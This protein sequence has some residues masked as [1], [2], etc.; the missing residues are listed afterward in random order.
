MTATTDSSPSQDRQ[1]T[2]RM[3][4]T[5]WAARVLV[6]LGLAT[7]LGALIGGPPAH[8]STIVYAAAQDIA[9]T[10][11]KVTVA[12]LSFTMSPGEVR[13]FRANLFVD[14]N[15]TRRTA[16]S[17]MINCY[18]AAGTRIDYIWGG[19]NLLSGQQ[20][21]LVPNRFNF[22][23]PLTAT[24]GTIT[25]RLEV[26][27]SALDGSGLGSFHVRGT[28]N[29]IDDRGVVGTDTATSS[30][31]APQVTLTSPRVVVSAHQT[32]TAFATIND[33]RIP[34]GKTLF[35]ARTD[36]YITE[37]HD[38]TADCNGFAGSASS[39]VVYSQTQAIEYQADGVTVCRN[40]F[41][42][43]RTTT[44]SSSVHHQKVFNEINGLSS[45][46]GCG[47][48]W[49]VILWIAGGAGNP[50]AL[51]WN[52]NKYTVAHVLPR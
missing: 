45:T 17:N 36:V 24:A 5:Q 48:R 26:A 21:V 31:V 25:C 49:K 18:N 10:S 51:T 37:C 7:V 19:Q 1:E 16:V 8:A 22:K 3:T 44:V 9:Q 13:G 38:N 12:Q 28:T 11:G 50:F 52:G 41:S 2:M 32:S 33:Y 4:I 46:P 39:S 27:A 29:L 35:D 15:T 47:N 23:L 6:T 34:A 20:N 43:T 40:W 30:P 14:S 42:A